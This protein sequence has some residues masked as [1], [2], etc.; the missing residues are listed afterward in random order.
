MPTPKD[1]LPMIRESVKETMKTH[2]EAGFS[3]GVIQDSDGRH[4]ARFY[5]G[6]GLPSPPYGELIPRPP[7]GEHALIHF[8]TH[9][10][11]DSARGLSIM[12]VLFPA[13]QNST[14]DYF[15]VANTSLNEVNVYQSFKVL[16]DSDYNR[17][18][19]TEKKLATDAALSMF[20]QKGREPEREY[21][22]LLNQ[23]KITQ[24]VAWLKTH[25]YAQASKI[26][27]QYFREWNAFMN[28][29]RTRVFPITEL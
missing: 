4:E 17:V 10:P 2:R 1:F 22:E 19:E 21:M 16:S 7:P 20:R 15:V 24:A 26:I 27:D 13:F 9:V 11:D 14:Y 29:T 25:G 5:L 23:N 3:V 18:I 6:T 12:D 8:H 28:K